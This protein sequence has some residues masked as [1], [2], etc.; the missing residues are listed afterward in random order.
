MSGCLGEFKA[1]HLDLKLNI[2]EFEVL[3]LGT[4]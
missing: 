2:E 1:T 3:N 4:D